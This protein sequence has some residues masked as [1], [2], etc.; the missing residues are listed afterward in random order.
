MD[1]ALAEARK[2]EEERRLSGFDQAALDLAAQAGF[3]F[4][5]FEESDDD[6][7]A[8]V[9]EFFPAGEVIEG[10]ATA[11]AAVRGANVPGDSSLLDRLEKAGQ[12]RKAA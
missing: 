8:V 2:T 12:S 1:E 11:S 5:A 9:E 10:L 4:G 3:G 7:G 6:V